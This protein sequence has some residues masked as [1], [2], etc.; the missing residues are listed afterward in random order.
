MQGRLVRLNSARSD[1]QAFR[2]NPE[3]GCWEWCSAIQSNGYAKAWDGERVTYAHR[4]MYERLLG[5]IPE[6][7]D[8]DHLC[9]NRACVNPAHLEA[10]TRAENLRRGET[11]RLTASTVEEIRAEY[12][13]GLFGYRKLAKKHGVTRQHIKAIITNK[14]WKQEAVCQ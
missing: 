8:L 9:R 6:G 14:K 13:P 2:V 5:K 10:V 12:D 1:G 11:T 7:Y 3:T 4:I